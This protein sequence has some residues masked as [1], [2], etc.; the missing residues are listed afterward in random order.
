[1]PCQG[2]SSLHVGRRCTNA[3]LCHCCIAVCLN[4]WN[5]GF[6]V[7][8]NVADKRADIEWP[9]N[10]CALTL[11]REVHV[12]VVLELSQRGLEQPFLDLD[13]QSL[14]SPVRLPRISSSYP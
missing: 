13:A 9:I 11:E 12:A 6:I 10:C 3:V 2:R 8:K 1:M 4:N 7:A 5:I 14:Y